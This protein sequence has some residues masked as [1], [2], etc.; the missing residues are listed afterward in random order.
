MK[1][2]FLLLIALIVLVSACKEEK[3]A[4]SPERVKIEK[5]KVLEII[6]AFHS[7]YEKKD[8]GAMIPTLAGEVVFFGTDSGEVITTFS[9]YK[10]KMLEQWQEYEVM[11]Y[12]EPY[13]VFIEM[14][15]YG[16]YASII[17]GVQL[18]VKKGNYENNY[19]IRA[20]RT[21]R[22]EKDN[23][24]IVSGIVSIPRSPNPTT[25]QQQRTNGMQ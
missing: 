20:A 19:Q 22:R 21:L 23:W 17:Y 4:L 12:G 8:F 9:D 11:K 2:F 15:P 7:A 3:V 18:Y 5:G 1:K 13:D 16:N 24:V 14:D 25:T 6:K 10:K